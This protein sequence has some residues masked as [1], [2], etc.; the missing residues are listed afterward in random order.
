MLFLVLKVLILSNCP[1][2]RG[3]FPSHLSSIEVIK[4]EGC[5]HL[6]E[7]P[8]TFQWISSIK[9][10]HIK[11]CTERAQWSLVGSDSP[12]QL[13]YVTIERCDKLLSL[14]K[15]IM[16]STRLQHLTLND[17]P[18][19]TVFPTDIQL[20]SLQSL[21]IS[22]CKSLSFLPPETWSN[23][24]SLVSLELWSICDA[25]TSFSLDGFPALERLHL[26]SCKNLDSIFISE[27]P[28]HQPSVLQSLKIKS[29]YSIGS[30]KVKLRMDTLTALEELSLGCRE[31]SFCE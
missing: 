3:H 28:S 11:G 8:P 10:I 16:R 24:T 19:F 20:I 23:Y 2:L 25:L 14:P 21:H 12:C 4:I 29:H 18:S 26:Y 1:K 31:L 7:I 15:M 13:Q 5:A 22:M 27:S 6:L 30:L 9:K 17:I